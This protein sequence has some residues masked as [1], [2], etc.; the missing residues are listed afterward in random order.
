M[1]R[2]RGLFAISALSL[3]AIAHDEQ[4][5]TNFEKAFGELEAKLVKLVVSVPLLVLAI[6]IV[7]CALWLGGVVSRRMHVLERISRSN[8]YMDGLLR[9]VVKTVI[10][11]L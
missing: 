11:L 2:C 8:P 3:P 10:V 4:M 6:L 7:M 9:N 1:A 5:K